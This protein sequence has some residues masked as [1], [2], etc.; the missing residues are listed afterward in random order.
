[1]T[2]VQAV[3]LFLLKEVARLERQGNWGSEVSVVF[4]CGCSLGLMNCGT[5]GI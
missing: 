5:Q 4:F 1:M 3:F 2:R